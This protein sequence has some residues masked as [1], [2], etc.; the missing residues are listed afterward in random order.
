MALELPRQ[1]FLAI[2][3][4]AWAD[5]LLKKDEAN[6][7]L[8]AAVHRAALVAAEG[9]RRPRRQL[10]ADRLRLAAKAGFDGVDLDEAGDFTPQ[11]ARAAVEMGVAPAHAVGPGFLGLLHQVAGRVTGHGK[12]RENHQI[13]TPLGSASGIRDHAVNIA[14]QVANSGVDL[15]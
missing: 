11:Q 14:G 13:G 12:F 9:R 2:V 5:G 8:R 4:V 15:P 1:S 7:L 6:G 10:V 3:A